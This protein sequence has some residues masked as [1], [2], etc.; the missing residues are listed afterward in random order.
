MEERGA[1]EAEVLAAIGA[2]QTAEVELIALIC[3]VRVW[4]VLLVEWSQTLRS[5][6][7]AC[8]AATL[9]GRI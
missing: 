8:D 2:L 6:R 7:R 1:A 9:E 5:K 3:E 4:Q